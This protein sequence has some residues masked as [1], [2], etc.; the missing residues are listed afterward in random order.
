VKEISYNLRPYQLDRIGMTKAIEA[1]VNKVGNS[2]EIEF[3]A[4]IQNVDGVLSKEAEI[5]LY[6]IIQESL[7]NIVKHSQAT[8]A[9]L[10]VELGSQFLSLSISDN[11]KG[12]ASGQT[13]NSSS[14][15][16]GLIGIAERVRMIGGT[17]SINSTPGHGTTIAIRIGRQHS[18]DEH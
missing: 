17:Y 10:V 8:E 7:N 14:S 9:K 11:G 6:R 3:A 12:F 2:T 18:S 1:L 15:G 16:F 5:N 13:T 4:D